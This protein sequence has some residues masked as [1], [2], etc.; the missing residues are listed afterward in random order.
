MW[1]TAGATRQK[2]AA[3]LTSDLVDKY[4]LI[5]PIH[6]ELRVGAGK[7]GVVPTANAAHLFPRPVSKPSK[8]SVGNWMV[9]SIQGSSVPLSF[10]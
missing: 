6:L 7:V 3:Q 8:T 4:V 9:W 1:V 10:I 2:R 5:S